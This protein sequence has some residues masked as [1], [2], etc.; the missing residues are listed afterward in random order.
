MCMLPEHHSR[1]A[2]AREGADDDFNRQASKHACMD[3]ASSQIKMVH[4]LVQPAQIAQLLLISYDFAIVR[5]SRA[6]V[7]FCR[8]QVCC[9]SNN[10]SACCHPLLSPKAR[11]GSCNS[12]WWRRALIG[13]LCCTR[14]CCDWHC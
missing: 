4:W 9:A 10:S 3:T 13:Q 6:L 1:R 7:L 14:C 11:L 12:D 5:H 2:K 8:M